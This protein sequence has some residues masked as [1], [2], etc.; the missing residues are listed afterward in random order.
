MPKKQPNKYLILTGAGMQM[1]IT[2]YLAA[3]LG[4]WLDGKYPNEKGWYTM[5]FVLFGVFASLYLLIKQV[6]RIND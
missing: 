6:N 2:I 5:G 1:G 3:Y 4:K